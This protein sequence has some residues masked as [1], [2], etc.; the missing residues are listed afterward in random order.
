MCLV[1]GLLILPTPAPGCW[2]YRHVPLCQARLNTR[3]RVSP[4]D[5]G[6]PSSLVM[7]GGWK[8]SLQWP[9]LKLSG[10]PLL[11]LF[12]MLALLFPRAPWWEQAVVGEFSLSLSACRGLP[13]RGF[14][15]SLPGLWKPW[16]DQ[17]TP[18]CLVPR[19]QR[20]SPFLLSIFLYLAHNVRAL[21]CS[22][23]RAWLWS[24]PS[25]GKQ[26]LLFEVFL[27]PFRVSWQFQAAWLGGGSRI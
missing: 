7:P 26:V 8:I 3:P 19:A 10:L 1:L 27:T 20:P 5:I 23:R 6:V 14:W 12:S 22:E 21:L 17:V 2:A 16:E 25:L 9:C 24:C 13:G 15:S 11:H 4:G 18:Q